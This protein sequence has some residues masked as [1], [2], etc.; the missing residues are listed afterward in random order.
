MIEAFAAMLAPIPGT[1]LGL[2]SVATLLT[3]LSPGPNVLLT[4]STGLRAGSRAAL[5]VVAGIMVASLVYLV[6]AAAWRSAASQA[7]ADATP[8]PTPTPT[9]A[10]RGP[11]P[12][13]Q[14]F[15]QGCLTHIANPKAV[16]FWTAVLPQFIDSHAPLTA[17]VITLGLL[18]M[19]IDAVVLASYG[20][21]AA[22]ARY[23]LL[24]TAWARRLD[25]TAG[26][27]FTLLGAMLALT[28]RPG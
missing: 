14:Y 3:C 25:L 6:V 16:L 15:W 28:H 1:R 17:Q 12:H 22:A 9:P 7:D 4:I 18:G 27:A 2:Y 21:S 13:G 23:S 19:V 8:T 26:I 10:P 20:L 5:T 11:A 24:T